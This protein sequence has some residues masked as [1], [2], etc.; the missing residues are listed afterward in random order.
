ME[1]ASQS[2]VNPSLLSANDSRDKL[3][4]DCN[5]AEVINHD[6]CPAAS[7]RVQT[8]SHCHSRRLDGLVARHQGANCVQTIRPIS[9][10]HSAATVDSTDHISHEGVSECVGFNV[11][12]DT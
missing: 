6:K 9:H 5:S 11:P 8:F 4:I 3:F 12:L 1:S 7:L 10:I 2:T